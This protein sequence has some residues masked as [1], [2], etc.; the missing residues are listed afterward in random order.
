MNEQANKQARERVSVIH[1]FIHLTYIH[2]HSSSMPK[3]KRAQ[4]IHLTKAKKKT[5]QDREPLLEKIQEAFRQFPYIYLIRVDN[6]RNSFLKQFRED[7][8]EDSKIFFGRVSLMSK[9][10]T[11]A[12]PEQDG[13]VTFCQHISGSNIGLVFSNIT[14]EKFQIYCRE[15]VQRDYARAGFIVHETVSIKKGKIYCLLCFVRRF[16]CDLYHYYYY[17]YYY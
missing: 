2:H 4:V 5:K 10:L 15:N 9:A 11:L 14:L 3:S 8:A 7:H 12:A 1:S 16:I 6:I 13:L 17:Y